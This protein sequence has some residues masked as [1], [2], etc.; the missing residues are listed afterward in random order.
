MRIP[1]NFFEVAS[2]VYDYTGANARMGAAEN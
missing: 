1:F 2:F